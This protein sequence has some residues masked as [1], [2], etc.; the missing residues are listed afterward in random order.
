MGECPLW[1]T[2][3]FYQYHP[4]RARGCS[5]PLGDSIAVG[6]RTWAGFNYKLRY[7]QSGAPCAEHFGGITFDSSCLRIPRYIVGAVLE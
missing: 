1:G 5:A 2:A 3:K 7:I 6:R 4:A